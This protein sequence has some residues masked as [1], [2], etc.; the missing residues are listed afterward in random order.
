MNVLSQLTVIV[1]TFNRYDKLL[2]LLKYADAFGCSFPFFI[3]DSSSQLMEGDEISK[4]IRRQNIQYVKYDSSMH[5]VDKI[6]DGLARVT[7]PYVVFWADD[8]FLILE[9]LKLGIEFLEKNR[10]FALVNGQNAKFA[11]EPQNGKELAPNAFCHYGSRGIYENTASQRLLNHLTCYSVTA[12]SIHRTEVIRRSMSLCRENHFG[13][14]FSEI[15]PSALS[16]IQGKAKKLEQLYMIKEDHPQNSS[17]NNP[18]Q[19]H[20]PFDWV[21]SSTFALDCQKMIQILGEEIVQVDGIN[22]EEAK[23]NAK[24]AIWN[25]LAKRMSD[26]FKS[27]F[28]SKSKIRKE[29]K[30]NKT[31]HSLWMYLRSFSWREQDRFLLPALKRKSS[32]YHRDFQAVYQ[33]IAQE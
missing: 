5:P 25:F 27:E 28:R 13:Y 19:I 14:Y 10:D 4:R 7:T 23:E 9:A 15:V 3:L 11:I 32:P 22:R 26:G 12:Y 29:L 24:K 33:W 17:W 2:R 18:L 20:N 21:T 31:L 16:V 30:K 8:D 6:C 1:L